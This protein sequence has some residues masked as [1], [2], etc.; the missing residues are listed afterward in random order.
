MAHKADVTAL[1]EKFVSIPTENP[2]GDYEHFVSVLAGAFRDAGLETHILRG[3]NDKPNVVGL[4]RGTTGVETLLLSG[5]MDVVPAG[6]LSLWRRPPFAGEVADGCLWGRGSA[7]MKGALACMVTAVKGLQE[8][9]FVPSQNIM[10]AGTVDDETAGSMGMNYLL[11]KGLSESGL[12]RPTFHVLGEATGL[13]LMVAFKGRIWIRITVQGKSAHGGSPQ[14]GINAIDKAFDLVACMRAIASGDHPM[15]GRD[16]CNL[17]TVHGGTA[18]NVV[19][20]E[21]AL[22]YDIRMGAPRSPDGYLARV[23]SLLAEVAVSSGIKVSK[24]EVLEKREPV[25]SPLHDPRVEALETVIVERTGRAAARLG[26]LSA[27]DLY[28]S[29]RAGIPGVWFGPGDPSVIHKTNEFVEI[30]QLETATLIYRGFM[31]RV[32]AE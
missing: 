10:L 2:P 14:E 16:T 21:C 1:A 19:P 17:G 28:Y 18:I 29:L 6:D 15:V 4:W 23:Q 5:H 11:A 7:D 24:L 26:T 27:G 20:A 3:R 9:G 22:E 30:G 25:E 8:A 12:P 13:N 32:C 31:E